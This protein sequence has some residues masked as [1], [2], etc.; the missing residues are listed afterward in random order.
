MQKKTI[1]EI[2]AEAWQS[3]IASM[4]GNPSIDAKLVSEFCERHQIVPES[5]VAYLRGHC[6]PAP[7]S[8]N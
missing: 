6:H 2:P 1:S 4:S 5:V 8:K 3:L 7:Q